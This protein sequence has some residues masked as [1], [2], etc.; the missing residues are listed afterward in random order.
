MCHVLF[1]AFYSTD[2][3]KVTHRKIIGTLVDKFKAERTHKDS[4]N[5]KKRAL[6]FKEEN[7]RKKG[8]EYNVPE[9]IEILI[10]SDSPEDADDIF[11]TLFGENNVGTGTVGTVG[12]QYEVT[13][14]I[15]SKEE[16]DRFVHHYQN[17]LKNRATNGF[18]N[19]TSSH[20]N[21]SQP[22]Q[23]LST[24]QTTEKESTDT[25]PM[26]DVSQYIYRVGHT[27]SWACKNCKL[28]GDTWFMRDHSCKGQS[29]K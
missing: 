20:L 18:E 11:D 8:R 15:V 10:D 6:E 28:K 3:G 25:S 27:D 29:S 13:T 22:S 1:V 14:T 9:K 16:W 21:T 7:L 19:T 26:V 17:I 24:E 4:G 2:L 23:L 12:T 5:D